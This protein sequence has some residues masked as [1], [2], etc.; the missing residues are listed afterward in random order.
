MFGS[1]HVKYIENTPLILRQKNE[2]SEA[3]FL[4]K[5]LD[6]LKQAVV[7]PDADYA[8]FTFLHDF[9]P[10][11]LKKVI[12]RTSP[13][14]FEHVLVDDVPK[15]FED[16]FI[17][18]CDRM[19]VKYRYADVTLEDWY[20]KAIDS[21]KEKNEYD[22]FRHIGRCCHLVQDIC[23]PMHCRLVAN[24]KD[25]F[26]VF[27]LKD[28][29]HEKFEKYCGQ[30]YSIDSILKE[31][32]DLDIVFQ[33]PGTMR[34]IAKASR[35]HIHACDGIVFPSFWFRLLQILGL[36]KDNEDRLSAANYTN[37]MAQINTVLFLHRVLKEVL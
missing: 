17:K 21:Y 27:K 22:F 5:N 8:E 37:S 25:V 24:F 15:V 6:I 28:T 36:V 10:E 11:E 1:L 30:T 18:I 12:P 34:E 7:T 2:I 14:K 3:E 20:G 26:D 16:V 23:V 31:K 29:N 9:L 13:I 19:G 33:I 4:E 32:I 35:E